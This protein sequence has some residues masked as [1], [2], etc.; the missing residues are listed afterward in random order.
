MDGWMKGDNAC[1]IFGDDLKRVKIAGRSRRL[2]RDPYR[3]N[4]FMHDLLVA[5]EILLKKQPKT[6]KVTVTI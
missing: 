3:I 2:K 5:S 1:S 4:D 6:Q